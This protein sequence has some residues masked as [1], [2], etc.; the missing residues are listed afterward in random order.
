VLFVAYL[1]AL[2]GHVLV[3]KFVVLCVPLKPALQQFHIELYTQTPAINAACNVALAF[4]VLQAT[5]LLSCWRS[6]VLTPAAAA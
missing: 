6:W 1:P 5:L 4:C 3:D 2:L